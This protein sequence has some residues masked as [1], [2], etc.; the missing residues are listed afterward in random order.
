M[1]PAFQVGDSPIT[2]ATNYLPPISPQPPSP[3]TAPAQP[4]T[5]SQDIHASREAELH[6]FSW[7]FLLNVSVKGKGLLRE[8]LC[9]CAKQSKAGWLVAA[10]RAELGQVN[11]PATPKPPPKQVTLPYD[12]EHQSDDDG[13]DDA[14]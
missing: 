6:L 2:A 12:E 11:R 5:M 1:G 4:E 9:E 14:A 7:G 8:A 13:G 10:A 3:I